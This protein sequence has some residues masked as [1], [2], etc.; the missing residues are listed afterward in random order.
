MCPDEE[1]IFRLRGYIACFP[2]GF[3]SPVRRGESIREIHQ[4]VPGYEE[5]LGKSVDRYFARMTLGQ[6]IGRMS[7]G[8]LFNLLRDFK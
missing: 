1:N 7:V 8:C 2:G 5:R 6:F 4:P 3:L